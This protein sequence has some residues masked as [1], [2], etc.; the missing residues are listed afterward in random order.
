MSQYVEKFPIPNIKNSYS[1]K[2][3]SIVKKI[4]TGKIIKD[5]S[6]YKKE[7]DLLI[8]NVFTIVS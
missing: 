2:A 3:I 7:L 6:S 8:N 4:I 1:Q 5:I